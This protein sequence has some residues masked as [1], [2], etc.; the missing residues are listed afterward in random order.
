MEGSWMPSLGDWSP[1]LSV[2][3]MVRSKLRKKSFES[4]RCV[5]LPCV[6]P[7]LRRANKVGTSDKV[8]G[9]RRRRRRKEE[10][11]E[12]SWSMEVWSTQ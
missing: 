9:R 8:A 1:A 3:R 10:G 2:Y 6:C 11:G 5:A 12:G 7:A 4:L